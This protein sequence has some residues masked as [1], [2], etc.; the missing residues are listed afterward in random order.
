MIGEWKGIKRD[1]FDGVPDVLVGRL[2]C[3]TIDQVQTVVDKIITYESTSPDEK[4][5]FNKLPP[6]CKT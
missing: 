5:W 3:R 1:V 2:A 6:V 4:P